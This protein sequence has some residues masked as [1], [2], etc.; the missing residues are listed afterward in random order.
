ML[1]NPWAWISVKPS[2][3][4]NL[5]RRYW[6]LKACGN[7]SFRVKPLIRNYGLR[8]RRVTTIKS[9]PTRRELR[10][11]HFQSPALPTLSVPYIGQ[12]NR[13]PECK[14]ATDTLQKQGEEGGEWGIYILKCMICTIWGN[15]QIQK[16]HINM[17]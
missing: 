12:T 2:Y 11:K 8:S 13:K 3:F 1:E 7:Y 5:N 6:L 9:Q 16:Y 10:N 14:G 15:A 4:L 17:I